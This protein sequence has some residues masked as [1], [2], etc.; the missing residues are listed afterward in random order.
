MIFLPPGFGTVNLIRPTS[1]FFIIIMSHHNSSRTSSVA[2][3]VL[4]R[5]TRHS[6]SRFSSCN[7]IQ[8]RSKPILL[9]EESHNYHQDYFTDPINSI[10]STINNQEDEVLFKTTKPVD[11][12]EI[13]T[14][15]SFVPTFQIIGSIQQLLHVKKATDRAKEISTQHEPFFHNS[16]HS[17]ADAEDLLQRAATKLK[18]DDNQAKE[19]LKLLTILFPESKLPKS[20]K[21]TACDQKGYTVLWIDS[22]SCGNFVYAGD[23]E[24]TYQCVHCRKPR[25]SRCSKQ[26]CHA[27]FNCSHKVSRT[28]SDQLNYRPLSLLFMQLLSFE[29]FHTA[30]NYEAYPSTIYNNTDDFLI[31]ISSGE[32]AKTAKN[33]M[34]ESFLSAKQD[35]SFPDCIPINL[36][37]S[38][39]FDGAQVYNSVVVDFA[40]LFITIENLPPSLRYIIGIGMFTVS[41]FTKNM[42]S[43]C[44]DFILHD[45][46]VQELK[47]FEE[48]IL[49]TVNN[50]KYFVQARVIL[51][52]YDTK[53][54]EAITKTKG[55]GGKLGCRKCRQMPG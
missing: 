18:L 17:Q 11:A 33:A 40:P 14:Y 19:L 1:Y 9:E 31:D 51:H 22:C 5:V 23:E 53:A 29:L 6:S 16:S 25:Y 44:Y 47:M 32:N 43:G 4:A 50:Q 10:L 39:N 54:L 35:D 28:P 26:S 20:L 8:L 3:S 12:N 30:I 36:L 41:L 15:L 21:S 45:C 38:I 27:V 52:R 55:T 48:G 37:F 2:R 24:E 34:K 49:M 13:C 42:H 7:S 46:F